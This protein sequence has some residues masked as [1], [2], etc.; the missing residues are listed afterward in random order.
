MVLAQTCYVDQQ[1]K[2]KD[3]NMN[4][5]NYI[6]LVFEKKEKKSYTGEK[7]ASSI[8]GSGKTGFL[9]AEE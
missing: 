1:N 4:A 8:N 5:Y 3:P 6:H 9:H 7:V 2:I